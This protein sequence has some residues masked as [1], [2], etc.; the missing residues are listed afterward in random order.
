M[1]CGEFSAALGKRKP[2]RTEFTEITEER[3]KDLAWA[4]GMKAGT[5][6][7]FFLQN[8]LAR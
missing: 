1:V 5:F 6:E 8:F 3:E 4:V 7:S 2:R